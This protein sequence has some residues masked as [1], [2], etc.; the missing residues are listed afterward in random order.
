MIPNAWQGFDF[1]LGSDVDM[2]RDTVSGFAQDHIAPRAAE[3]DRSNTFPRELW[4]EMG[5]LGL[6]G[7]EV[8]EPGVEAVVILAIDDMKNPKQYETFLRPI[9][10]RLKQIDGRAPV[11]IMTNHVDPKA[12]ELQKWLQEG[13]SIEV[14]DDKI[15]LAIYAYE[16]NGAPVYYYAAGPMTGDRAF[17]S[18]LYKTSNG[19]CLG[20]TARTPTSTLDWL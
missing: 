13:V 8:G 15:F 12:P 2:L 7:M 3:I 1:G 20:C 4:P 11:S 10:R 16:Q 9:L 14:Q 17:S 5:K 18:P 6:L 19:Q